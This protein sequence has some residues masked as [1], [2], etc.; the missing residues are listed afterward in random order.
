[1]QSQTFN[2]YIVVGT[3]VQNNSTLSNEIRENEI[4]ENEI[5]EN[6]EKHEKYV[7][8]RN[9]AMEEHKWVNNVCKYC[10][11]NYNEPPYLAGI[12]RRRTEPCPRQQ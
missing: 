12:Y 2:D 9:S 7:R 6:R 11:L 3:L 1:M 8:R 10:R 4:R 5:R